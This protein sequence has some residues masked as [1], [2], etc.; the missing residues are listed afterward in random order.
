MAPLARVP[1][2]VA[3][4]P[5]RVPALVA[6]AAHGARATPRSH[7][8]HRRLP[9][10][11]RALRGGVRPARS[12]WN[13]RPSSAAPSDSGSDG[14]SSWGPAPTPPAFGDAGVAA[15]SPGSSPPP[16]S[17]SS[18]DPSPPAAAAAAA[19]ARGTSSPSAATP[20]S[21]G[22]PPAI[23][24]DAIRVSP[25]D[26][27]RLGPVPAGDRGVNFALFSSAASAVDL[28]VYF[29]PRSTSREPSL[30]I[31]LDP[32]LGHKTGDV[33]HARVDNIPR[34][35]DGYQVRYGY[36]VRGEDPPRHRHDR[37]HPDVLL[38][39]P[40][41]PLIDGRRVYGDKHSAPNGESDH[42]MGAF[43]FDETP[44]DWEG[45]EPPNLPPQ[46]LV[47]YELTTRAYTASDTSGVAPRRRGSFLA[48][49][50][51]VQHLKD[52]GV[53]AVELL[54]VFHFDELEFQR[55]KNPR[56]HMLNTWGYSTMSFFAP[57]L[58]Y[59][60]EGA[61]PAAAARE[62]KHMVKTLHANGIEVLLDVVYNHTG[63]GTDQMPNVFSFRGID[64]R[65]YY[66]ME[67]SK[68]PYK[69]YTGCG[70]TFNC[71]HPVVKE[72]VLD[73]LRHWVTEYHVDGFRFDLT[74]A[75]T[76]DQDGEPMGR[77]PVIRDIAKDPTL[78]RCKLF[79]EPWDCGGLY[80]VGSFPNWDR[81]GEWN[82]KYRDTLRR[83]VKGDMGLKSE[84]ACRLSGSS[85][86]YRTNARKPY[87]SLNF[88]TAHDGFTLR[89]LVSYN[90]KHNDANG[91]QNR[92]GCNDN[93]SWNHG[94]EG[95]N[96]DDGVRALRWR[97]MKNFHLALMVSQGTPMV[98]MGDE[99]GHTRGGNNNTYGHDNHLNNFD[100]D[101]LER[102]RDGYFRFHSGMIKFRVAHPL[103]GRAEFL[104]DADVT[105]HEDN[106]DN[107]ESRFLAFTLH[108]RGQ[109]GGDLYCAF[110][111]HEFYVDAALPPPPGGKSWHRVVD[112]NLPSPADFT[113]EGEPGC[114]ARYN[115]APRG[116][117]L[118]IAK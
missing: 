105:W 9:P 42:W 31:P 46:D 61:G 28:C 100:W 68:Y 115:V 12:S 11:R 97:Q 79:A 23:D 17:S 94:G 40:Y 2:L 6:R 38:C 18:W 20:L 34:G 60:S 32:A 33:W 98:L 88:V 24:V 7:P 10:A 92:D 66:M 29:D 41:A 103:L 104:T 3:P 71:N 109:G 5:S 91:E 44:F 77:P 25:G 49:A 95:E 110:N 37:W 81:W 102:V 22:V 16:A 14:G 47:V 114:G 43:A 69:N 64:N 51:K 113:P 107:P 36:L 82:G 70:N 19:A 73:S 57:M 53:N 63:E 15:S 52:A 74:S 26:A 84:L 8:V 118:L 58:P 55:A 62:F 101:A 65:A 86:M 99:Y 1:A 75:M 76:R 67:D 50:E 96:V 85:D 59:A 112:T 45:V 116:A 21:P 13:D 83:F 89:D 117:V 56:D 48:L 93:D 72:L 87:H 27:S 30:R 35:H 106:W 4:S 80:Q 39:D 78:A 111:A 108:D 54:P 90:D